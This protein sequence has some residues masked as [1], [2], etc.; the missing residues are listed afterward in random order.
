MTN[1]WDVWLFKNNFA[2]SRTHADSLINNHQVEYLLNSIWI[3]VPKS[4]QKVPENITLDNVRVLM[5]EANKFVSRGGIKLEG[6]LNYLKLIP[7]GFRVLDLGIST[8]GF[9]DCLLQNNVHSVIG[10]D[11]GH[12]QLSPKLKQH[13]QLKYFDGINVRSLSNYKDQ[14]TDLSYPFDLIVGD[15]SF[16]SLT[17]IIPELNTF[18]KNEGSILLLVKPQF[19]LTPKDL[20]KSGVVKNPKLYETVKEKIVACAISNKYVVIDFFESPISGKDGNKEF[21]VY[22]KKAKASNL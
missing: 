11:V 1:R 4:S 19:E 10:V 20:N 21:F 2:N 22:L 12:D 14:I 9:T 6:A 5:G 17:L 13:S 15:L 18:L 3:K 16:I 8:G 7:A